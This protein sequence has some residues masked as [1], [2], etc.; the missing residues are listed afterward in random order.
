MNIESYES[1]T[2]STESGLLID[3]SDDGYTWSNTSINMYNTLFTFSL[4]E[5]LDVDEIT[6]RGAVVPDDIIIM[7][8]NLHDNPTKEEI[9][10]KT[11][12]SNI[13]IQNYHV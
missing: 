10:K 8:H 1:V 5:I 2:R 6:L 13:F 12:M 11:I 3:G 9:E 4:N 7:I